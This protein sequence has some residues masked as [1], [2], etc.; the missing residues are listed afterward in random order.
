MSRHPRQRRYQIYTTR[1]RKPIHGGLETR[2]CRVTLMASR[3]PWQTH[4]VRQG[5]SFYVLGRQR[6]V[7]TGPP[8][9]LGYEIRMVHVLR[10]NPKRVGQR[11]CDDRHAVI[12][13]LIIR[14]HCQVLF[15]IIISFKHHIWIEENR[16]RVIMIVCI[17]DSTKYIAAISQ[18][19]PKKQTTILGHQIDENGDD[20]KHW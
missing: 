17:M 12:L 18:W 8:P 4:A 13:R 11:V 19:N 5:S 1:F 7:V 3:R 6:Q 20:S 16:L 2:I 14:V 15:S 9:V 10:R